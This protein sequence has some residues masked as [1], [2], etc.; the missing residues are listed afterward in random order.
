MDSSDVQSVANPLNASVRCTLVQIWFRIPVWSWT[1][2]AQASIAAAA[3][4]LAGCMVTLK[5]EVAWGGG[6]LVDCT[7]QHRCLPEP[8]HSLACQR[9][10]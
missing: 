1:W 5:S 8:L 7:I 9:P 3:G 6:Y 4:L 10:W 2:H